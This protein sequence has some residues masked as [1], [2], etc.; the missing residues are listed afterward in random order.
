MSVFIMPIG[1]IVA[2]IPLASNILMVVP[3]DDHTCWRWGVTRRAGGGLPRIPGMQPPPQRVPGG[4]E[5]TALPENDYLIDR[6][7]QR[8]ESYTGIQGI[9]TQDLAVT[10][11]MGPIYD[12]TSEHLGTTD[13]AIIRMRR[14]LIK[15][16]ED[17]QKG[18]DPPGTDP[19]YPYRE[20]R[21]AE[22]I[23]GPVEDWTKLA[24]RDEP[25][26]LEELELAGA[27]AG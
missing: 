9:G 10:E 21:S 3:I 18:I 11:S 14:L 26:L 22:K 16:A 12:R 4:A 25:A 7:K 24:T 13:L 5:R 15:A 19:A 27:T 1:T 23:L 20:I 2:N 8:T 17:L 6:Q